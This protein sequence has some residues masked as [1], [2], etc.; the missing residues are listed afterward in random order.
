MSETD[1]EGRVV[2]M[3]GKMKKQCRSEEARP[4]SSTMHFPASTVLV[5]Q[6][7]GGRNMPS[8]FHLFDVTDSRIALPR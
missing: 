3:V 4:D 6:N 8:H 1:G 2:G 7:V 5:D